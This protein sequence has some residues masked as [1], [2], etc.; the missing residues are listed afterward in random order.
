MVHPYL[1]FLV[2]NQV[3]YAAAGVFDD[4]EKIWVVGVI[5]L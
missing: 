1:R 3:A 4:E 2:K 5:S